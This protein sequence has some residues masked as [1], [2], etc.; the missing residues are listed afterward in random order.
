MSGTTAARATEVEA[1]SGDIQKCLSNAFF[2][3]FSF[4]FSAVENVA[5]GYGAPAGSGEGEDG[6]G[7]DDAAARNED[8][9]AGEN[10]QP[11]GGT[12]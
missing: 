9:Y 10:G 1:G 2:A 3:E 11:F 7:N 6:S 5:T 4:S 8:D 12:D